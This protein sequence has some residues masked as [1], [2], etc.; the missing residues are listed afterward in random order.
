M[1]IV[2]ELCEAIERDLGVNFNQEDGNVL[3]RFD[4]PQRA[5]TPGQAA[6]FYQGEELIGGGVIY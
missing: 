3:L 2:D 1:A 5:P 6:V 4:Q